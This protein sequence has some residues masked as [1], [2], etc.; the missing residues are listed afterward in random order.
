MQTKS[1]E[2]MSIANANKKVAERTKAISKSKEVALKVISEDSYKT[3]EEKL[4]SLDA[5]GISNAIDN[6]DEFFGTEISEK[7]DSVCKDKTEEGKKAFKIDYF[8]LLLSYIDAERG[9]D[10][11]TEE[12]KVQ[13]DNFVK[14]LDS[15][16]AELNNGQL[17]TEQFRAIV[18]DENSTEEK[19]KEAR[20][21]LD[22][23]ENVT[24]MTFFKNKIE[25][26][27]GKLAK[28]T[29]KNYISMKTKFN[30]V[31]KNSNFHFQDAS[32]LEATLLKIYPDNYDEIK[33]L[34]YMLYK[35]SVGTKRMTFDKSVF[36]NYSIL[37]MATL[38]L[39]EVKGFDAQTF[40]ESL[41][42]VMKRLQD[43]K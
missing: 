21:Y 31:L 23:L 27:Q 4:M 40:R 41:D 3:I 16:I 38:L 14:E 29:K 19:K 39:P 33:M 42:V 20:I 24:N 9:I 36:I 25:N 34:L 8:K 13:N 17:L 37:S 10:N 43:I 28:E 30:K 15:I 5:E 6:I 1:I 35:E 18:E 11:L 22:I 12:L 32:L 2:S 26:V 7:L